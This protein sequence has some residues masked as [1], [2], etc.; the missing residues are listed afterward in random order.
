MLLFDYSCFFFLFSAH[1]P[2]SLHW[3]QWHWTSTHSNC[4]IVRS[5]K[6]VQHEK[7]NSL[8]V[9][10]FLTC[11]RHCNKVASGYWGCVFHCFSNYSYRFL[12]EVWWPSITCQVNWL[13]SLLFF[14]SSITKSLTSLLKSSYVLCDRVAQPSVISGSA[15]SDFGVCFFSPTSRVVCPPGGLMDYNL[16]LQETGQVQ[17]LKAVCICQA[18]FATA[19]AG[20][21]GIS[22]LSP[23][24]VEADLIADDYTWQLSGIFLQRSWA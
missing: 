3:C 12:N 2:Q 4:F 9:S 23:R 22:H 15:N 7:N 11:C 17:G 24:W 16:T 14:C 20:L 10:T 19:A 5:I 21:R 13:L 18:K 1:Y 8:T 6:M